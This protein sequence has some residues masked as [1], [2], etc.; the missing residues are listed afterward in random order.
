MKLED[1][2]CEPCTG[3]ST[4]VAPETIERLKTQIPDWH[5]KEYEDCPHLVRCYHL[6]NYADCLRFTINV[7]E[8]ADKEDHHPSIITTWGKVT[9][10]WWTH[11]INNL[12]IND[13]VMAAKTDHIYNQVTD[14]NPA[15]EE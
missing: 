11:A 5:I 1:S 8:L 7:G 13:F 4:A 6:D 12:H 3:A 10:H 15:P 9:I 2:H 14:G